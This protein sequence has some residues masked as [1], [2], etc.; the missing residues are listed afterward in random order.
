[1]GT[2]E[3]DV[4]TPT[5]AAEPSQDERRVRLP[6]MAELVAL[7]LRRRI[8]RNELAEGEA[9]P[10]EAALMSQYGVSRPTL[11]EALRVLES[12]SLIVIQRGAR[13]GARV[14]APRREVAARYAGL[15]LQYQGTTL[16][17]VCEVRSLLEVPCVRMLARRGRADD[18]AQLRGA[19]EAAEEAGLTA[20]E[21]AR[22]HNDFHQLLLSLTGNSTLVLLGQLVQEIIDQAG[23]SRA[24]GESGPDAELA[25]RT[26]AEAHRRLIE[27]IDVGD[28]GTAEA[29][30]D[31][32][33]ADGAAHA[34]GAAGE[35][36]LL[37]ILT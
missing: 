37:D 30:W 23:V 29:L 25:A 6:K 13:G 9:L 10:G 31:K 22:R 3:E 28:A 11:R 26:A 4:T 21:R 24:Q 32:H 34:F 35:E 2:V 36:K 5:A 27:L 12:E 1:M 8:I 33:L 19:L 16:A 15:L 18:I 20:E 7:D 17:D 14:C